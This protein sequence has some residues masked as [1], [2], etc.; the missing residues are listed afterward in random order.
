MKVY[1]F[2]LL[3]DGL[4]KDSSV[5]DLCA[6][7]DC[8]TKLDGHGNAFLFGYTHKKKLAKFFEKTRN[9]KRL[10]KVVYEMDKKSYDDFRSK[11]IY[12][13]IHLYDIETRFF[14]RT[15]ETNSEVQIIQFPATVSEN[16]FCSDKYEYIDDEFID[17]SSG[18]QT[19]FLT[20]AAL[21]N[22]AKSKIG[23]NV[24]LD[25]IDKMIAISSGDE[26]VHINLDYMMLLMIEFPELYAVE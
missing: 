3:T 21:K 7:G 23:D 4:S 8:A 10:V 14:E 11:S 22:S 26:I 13:Q 17:V 2:Y 12:Q 16:D 6:D 9:M 15:K 20:I 18:I 19:M 1:C 5:L 25:I 24:Y